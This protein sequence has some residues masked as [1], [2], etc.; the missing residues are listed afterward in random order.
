MKTKKELDN[1]KAQWLA[2]PCWDIYHT[3]GFEEYHDEL[4]AF[5]EHIEN[6]AW[7]KERQRKVL[8]CSLLGVSETAL[9]YIE[10][11]EA[12]IAKLEELCAPSGK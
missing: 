9:L 2:D 12:R 10:S 4:Y 8:M 5:Q 3:D 7:E 6:E 1:L 11:L